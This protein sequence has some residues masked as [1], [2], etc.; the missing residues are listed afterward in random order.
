M[1]LRIQGVCLLCV[2]T[3]L[4]IVL[5]RRLLGSVISAIALLLL[6]SG[7]LYPA[8]SHAVENLNRKASSLAASAISWLLLAP[9]YLVFFS[10][11]HAL[12]ALRHRDPLRLKFP[13]DQS[14]QS[15]DW[16]TVSASSAG[17]DLRRPY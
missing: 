17:E 13:S 9:F 6:I 14:T 12:L 3:V 7:C 4:A 15:S 10:A 2:G 16:L 1:S 5:H 11:G 8:L